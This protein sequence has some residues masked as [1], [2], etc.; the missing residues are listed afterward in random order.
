VV[1]GLIDNGAAK[2]GDIQMQIELHRKTFLPSPLKLYLGFS[3]IAP[4]LYRAVQ[5]WRLLQGKE[6]PARR[7]ER[8]GKTDLTRPVGRLVWFHA[9]S[10]GESLSLLDL[11]RAVLA[12]GAD[13][14]VLITTSSLSSARL[15]S[16]CLP[17]R[18]T[19]QFAPYDTGAAVNRFLLHWRPDV[20]VWTESELWPRMLHETARRDIP[21][22]LVSARVSGRTISR[23]KRWPHGVQELMAPFRKIQVQEHALARLLLEVGV[24]RDRVEVAGSLKEDRS[25][26]DVAFAVLADMTDRLRDRAR[27]LA[28]STH[29]GEDATLVAAHLQAFGRGKDA[30]LLIIAPRHPG[31]GPALARW[32]A[33]Q[34]WRVALRSRGELPRAETEIYVADTLGEMGLWY[35]VCKLA[36]VGGSLVSVGGHNPYEPVRLGCAVIHGPNVSNFKHIYSLLDTFGGA[37]ASASVDQ[38]AEALAVLN[39]SAKRQALTQAAHA[40]LRRSPSATAAALTA[41]RA[42]LPA[43]GIRSCAQRPGANDV[44][45]IAPNFKRRISGVTSTVVRL[46]PL[47]AALISIAAAAPALLPNVPQ[48]SLWSL[49][50]MSRAG[51]EGCRV[52]HA[53]R[54][55]EMLAG[56]ALRNFLGKRLK[57]VFTSASQRHHS[58][59]TRMLIRRMDAVVATSEKSAGY[60]SRPAHIIYHGIDTSTFSPVKYAGEVRC[61]LGLPA[62]GRLIGCFGRIRAEKGTD[63][64]VEAAIKLCRQYIDLRAVI[65]GR[66]T[67]KDKAFLQALRDR[68]CTAGLDDRILFRSEVPVWAM[69]DWYRALDVYVAPQRW[70]GFGLTPLEAMA[71]GVPVVASDVGAFASLVAEG[72]TGFIVAPGSA[73]PIVDAVGVLLADSDKRK[74]FASLARAHV[75]AK[76]DIRHEAMALVQ[77]YRS[78]LPPG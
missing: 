70:E 36:F 48:V 49:L 78:L 65:L 27:W 1:A 13:I 58:R 69:A 59:Y 11:V 33:D 12:D 50:S 25:P 43:A 44:V 45:V 62:D 68:V 61:Q 9:A 64:F 18:A 4:P 66:A 42:A 31:R 28:A 2:V 75:E 30:P 57:L 60:L 17:S 24:P 74:A 23:W 51:P 6:C 52:W 47:Q 71:C 63:L 10:I 40:A 41:I 53:R 15:V 7:L 34:G 73:Q 29:E 5:F 16:D 76:F 3:S 8:F 19:H 55:V 77:L 39:D 72:E 56:L 20:A 67:F 26:L 38:V 37:L 21:M 32:L 22:F 54:N 46:V 14:H 35:R